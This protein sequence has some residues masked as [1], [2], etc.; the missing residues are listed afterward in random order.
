MSRYQRVHSEAARRESSSW[1][2]GASH[3]EERWQRGAVA[4]AALLLYYCD[5]S[6]MP[7]SRFNEVH[8]PRQ[9]LGVTSWKAQRCLCAP[10]TIRLV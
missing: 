7:V 6:S 1:Q 10:Q 8:N 2:Y 9:A 3:C 4:R 5:G